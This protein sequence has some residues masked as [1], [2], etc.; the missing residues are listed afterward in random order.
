MYYQDEIRATDEFRTN[1]DLVKDKEL[2]MA[3]SLI[4]ALAA[5]FEPAKFKDNYRETLRTMIDAKIAGEEVVAAPQSEEVGPVI[6]I[7]EALRS[8]LEALKKPATVTEMP[9]PE[10]KRRAGG[11]GR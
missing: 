4:D 3:Q 6:D 2:I 9:L 7:M 8:S 10:E 11:R 5:P 1:V